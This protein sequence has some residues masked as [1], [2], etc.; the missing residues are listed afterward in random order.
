MRKVI[1]SVAAVLLG[2]TFVCAESCKDS[3]VKVEYKADEANCGYQKRTC[4][5]DGEWSDWDKACIKK[6][7]YQLE[8]KIQKLGGYGTQKACQEYAD[9][10]YSTHSGLG[11]YGRIENCDASNTGQKCIVSACYYEVIDYGTPNAHAEY[12]FDLTCDYCGCK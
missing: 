11:Q 7:T 1:L 3:P 6:C 4:C 9:Y 12:F 8:T 2:I 5:E 10:L